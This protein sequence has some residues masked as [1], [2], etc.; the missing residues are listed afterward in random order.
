M[1]LLVEKP[2]WK[3]ILFF[4]SS[5]YEKR[6]I[7]YDIF[8]I[9]I[10]KELFE[11]KN[12]ITQYEEEHKWELAKKLANPYEMVYTQEEK[13]PYQNVSLL[14]P[15]SRSYFKLIEILQIVGFIKDLPKE[16]QFLRS[17][18]IAEGP[19]G[20]M[21]A[22][23]DVVESSRRR[24]KKID[25]ITLRSDKQC[26]PGWKKASYF[27]KK[28]SNIINISYG[29]DGTGDIYKLINQDNFIEEV[30]SKVNLFTADG[31]FD[32]S[33]DYSQQ[34]KQIFKLLASSFLI[35]FQILAI[36]GLCVIKLFD[37][38]SE[39]TRSL[40]SL[41]GSC[42]KEYSL[43]KPATSRPCNSERYFIGKKF[44]GFNPKIVESLKVIL[45]NIDNDMYPKISISL[46]ENEYIENMSKKYE[47]K[48]I[49]CI[50]LAK[51]FAEDKELFT[52]YYETYNKYC[53]KFCEEFKI[54]IKK[55]I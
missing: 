32:F 30:G 40:I 36:N 10:S 14:K 6:E 44:R 50:D 46:E 27:L 38:Y 18:H 8:S 47:E 25:A 33:I 45:Y 7:T 22:F 24:I 1:E 41:C 55:P 37:T 21:Q 35:G 19:G 31:G 52:E 17:A 23:I 53:Y 5:P 49:E 26:I 28:Y 11:K 29:K 54:P 42:F 9:K 51:K 43:Y 4:K 20:F 12:E 16:V 48:Q 39:S 13:F 15:L 3:S 2:P 34:E